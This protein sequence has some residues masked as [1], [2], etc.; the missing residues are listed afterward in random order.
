MRKI[1]VFVFLSLVLMGGVAF[2]V[3]TKMNFQGKLTDSGGNPI[4]TA[5]EVKFSI[6]DASS[7]GTELWTETISGLTPDQG[8]MNQELGLTTPLT[9][10]VFGGDTRY[11]AIKVGADAEMTP[12]IPL[13]SVPFAFRAAVA[14]SIV[15]GQA[16][17][18]L[19]S[20][21]A[22][23]LRDA[24]TLSGGTGISL[25]Q[26]GQ[27]IQITSVST[28]GGT[29]TQVNTGSG[30]AG[31]PINTTGTVSI[32]AGGI[33]ATHLG[34]GVVTNDAI[35]SDTITEPKI[36]VMNDPVNNYLL[37]YTA[38]GL[39]WGVAGGTGT[40]T[41][42]DTGSGLAG[43]PINT[44]GTVSIAA[45]GINATHLGTG[46][47]TA[48]AI[49]SNAVI[50]A[51][52]S[53]GAVTAAKIGSGQ[54][55]TSFASSGAAALH[56]AVTLS[57]GSG[58]SL[59]Q[60]GQN[61]QITAVSTAGGTV[62]QV[63]TQAPLLGGPIT[64]T[65]TISI[66]ASSATT[67]GYLTS[68]DWNIFNNKL[69]SADLSGYV[70]LGPTTQQ[71]TTAA[72]AINVKTTNATGFGISSEVNT[73]A[74]KAVTGINNYS[75]G[76]MAGYFQG[77][78]VSAG[79]L[80]VGVRGSI[81][82]GTT[83][84]D[85]AHYVLIE[86]SGTT[87]TGV[88]GFTSDNG[89]GVYG[90]GDQV[91]V[92][93]STTS[94]TG[95]GVRGLADSA[96][97]ANIGGY[98]RSG[99]TSG[100]YGV[101]AFASGSSGT[102]YA[103]YART[104][105]PVDG[106][107]VYAE[108][109][110]SYFGGYTG[111]GTDNP[112]AMLHVEGNLKVTGTIEGGSPVKFAGGIRVANET[113]ATAGNIRW[114]GSHFEGF[115]GTGWVSFDASGVGGSGTV[116]QVNTSSPITGGPITTTGTIAINQAGAGQSGYLSSADWNT[117]NNKGSGTIG[118]SAASS[119]VPYGSGANTLT[120]A[121][122]FDF[123]GT[124]LSVGT[125]GKAG[126]IYGYY[127]ATQYGYLGDATY[128]VYGRGSTGVYGTDGTRFGQLGTAAFG[129]TG[130]NG[131]IYG[132]LASSSYG[133]YGYYDVND[134]GF[135]GSSN[136]GVYGYSSAGYG[137]DGVTTS[138]IGVQGTYNGSRYGYLGS[139]SYGAYGLYDANNFGFLGSSNYGVYGYTTATAGYG[140]YGLNA[141]ATGN[142]VG[143]Y[144]NSSSS[145]GRGVNGY[146]S[147]SGVCYG[148]YGETNSVS[149]I[150]VRGNSQADPSNRYGYLGSNS[151]GS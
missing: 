88:Y 144:G 17:T 81:P 60:A 44:T 22:T 138:G 142:S 70:Q 118:G 129:A 111:I 67:D 99:S 29:V 11:L 40:V 116:T 66:P 143:V 7:G 53:N 136:R 64:A 71:S 75:T 72:Y 38:T 108:G 96:G 91:G 30:L 49:A 13:A 78:Q 8:L 117:F 83:Y 26:A 20:T 76:G 43:G 77:G 12:R 19:A 16:I 86:D 114:N 63:N 4:T 10:G 27:N 101:Y 21:G 122:N 79:G 87:K 150:G 50:T 105:S 104:S 42:V 6:F 9:S 18:S 147:G 2:A 51:G 25:I 151:Y 109:G 52:I 73:A 58:I 145:T 37:T 82:G 46:I 24:V 107:A 35:A 45:G 113:D 119:K 112:Q 1:L 92:L 97:G 80:S 31:G 90:Q 14:D 123:D 98:F 23:P 133:A 149:G 89:S 36:H 127:S 56:D 34:S 106:Y 135:L 74:G 134:Y 102:N 84:G 15:A 132:Y 5:V 128:G 103:L 59:V 139:A 32:A 28:A 54:V 93:G 95:T 62:S 85:L 100:G 61:I 131:S 121:T 140:V 115:N 125:T 55:V 57:G 126:R 110:R 148:V 137:V 3:P 146:A 39:A 120:Y 94:L 69:G 41:Q 33:N 47:V 68:V 130:Q 124:S 141:G 48:G 65:G